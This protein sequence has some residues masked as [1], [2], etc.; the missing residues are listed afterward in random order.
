MD[1]LWIS[2]YN[3]RMSRKLHVMEDPIDVVFLS[4]L[5]GFEDLYGASQGQPRDISHFLSR[6]SQGYSKDIGVL[7]E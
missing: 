5:G 2:K 6:A 1:I 7:S 4:H 3:P